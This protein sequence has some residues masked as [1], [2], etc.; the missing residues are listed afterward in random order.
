MYRRRLRASEASGG[1][2]ASGRAAASS[3]AATKR[4]AS[5]ASVSCASAG[6]ASPSA[7]T[8]TARLT[9]SGCSWI[10]AANLC[11]SPLSGGQYGP[12]R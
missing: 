12:S 8:P 11:E 7:T 6:T 5:V 1:R 4:D 2:P 3:S 10:N 9:G